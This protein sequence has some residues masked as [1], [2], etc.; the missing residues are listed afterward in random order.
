MAQYKIKDAGLIDGIVKITVYTKINIADDTCWVGRV[1]RM[2]DERI[3]K[4]YL[5]G[6]F[7]ITK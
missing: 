3:S 5:N 1:M 4:K 2:E 7:H 6:K